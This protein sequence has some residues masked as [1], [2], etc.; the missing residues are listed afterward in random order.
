MLVRLGWLAGYEVSS[1]WV[2]FFLFLAF[3]R[4]FL[5]YAFRI[6]RGLELRVRVF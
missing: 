5:F 2:G 1:T 3:V 4:F 6:I